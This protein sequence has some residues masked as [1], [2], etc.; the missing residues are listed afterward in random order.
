M[1]HTE[2]I[3]VY[4]KDSHGENVVIRPW[5]SLRIVDNGNEKYCIV[6]K[7]GRGMRRRYLIAKSLL[8]ED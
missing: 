6:K 3:V 2:D 7:R 5:E 1:F 8:F 4:G